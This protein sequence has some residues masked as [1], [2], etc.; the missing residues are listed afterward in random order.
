MPKEA[1]VLFWRRNMYNY[2][3]DP[4]TAIKSEVGRV[5]RYR[6]YLAWM[7]EVVDPWLDS[8][9]TF[10]NLDGCTFTEVIK[11]RSLSCMQFWYYLNGTDAKLYFA[12]FA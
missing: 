8:P 12:N 2:T 4:I 7:P 9:E 11:N 5:K 6:P 1:L 3:A 10:L